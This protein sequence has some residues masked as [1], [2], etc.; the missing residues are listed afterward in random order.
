MLAQPTNGLHLVQFR[1]FDHS[2]PPTERGLSVVR[3]LAPALRE[4]LRHASSVLIGTHLNPDGDALG[5]ALAMSMYLDSQKI[6]NEIVCH[7]EPP[8][9]LQFLPGSNRVRLEPHGEKYDLGIILDLDAMERL[10]RTE[11]YFA[12]CQRLV[13]I[14]HHI[15]HSAPGDLRIVDTAAPATAVILTRLLRELG[16]N[17]TPQMATCLLT[18]IVTD[19]GSFRFR[20]TTPEALALSAFLLEQG[21]DLNQV[22]EEVFQSKTLGSVKLLGHA[23][24]VMRLACDN[25]IA[26]SCLSQRDF[27]LAQ[28]RDEDTEGFV[29]EMLFVT[30]VQIA[31]LLREPKPGRIRCSLR[32]RGDFDVAEVARFFGGGGHKNA[33]GCTLDMPLEEAE[34]QVVERLKACL[35]SC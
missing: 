25:R 14:D 15:P 12:S 21:G 33:A 3:E 11:A 6:E 19:T 1:G 16:A 30:S 34:A 23:L 22:S 4:E 18:G 24:E 13:V 26:W 2:D 20:N 17:I 31:A 32:S 5:S 10:G 9:N 27:E 7:H 8:R 29:N 28:G 35:A